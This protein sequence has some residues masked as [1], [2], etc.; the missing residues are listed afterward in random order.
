MS[1]TPMKHFTV[2]ATATGIC[3]YVNELKW[4]GAGR[5]NWGTPTDEIAPEAEELVAETETKKNVDVEKPLREEESPHAN[6]DS[7]VA[8]PEEK[9]PEDKEMNLE[10]YEKVLEEKRKALVTLK[11][12]ERKVDAKEFESM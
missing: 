4:E 3:F 10:E 1:K 7:P 5:G 2:T 11:T 8:K 6:K 9:E 12:E